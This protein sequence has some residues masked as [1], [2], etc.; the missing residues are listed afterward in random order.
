MYN[1]GFAWFTVAAVLLSLVWS[2]G[3]TGA[4]ELVILRMV[5]AIG[6]ALLMA[7]SAAIIT[8]AFPADQLG[9]ALGINMVAG[10]LRLFLGHP[11]RRAA[12]PGRAGAGC[13]W[14]TCRSGSSARSGPT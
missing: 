7:N 9:L 4:L 2:T 10:D 3:S 6:G 5:Q 8:D 14:P 12:V 1:L 11:R 13:S